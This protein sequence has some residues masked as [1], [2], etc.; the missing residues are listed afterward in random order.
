MRVSIAQIMDIRQ[1][2]TGNPLPY[3]RHAKYRNLQ[4]N[5]EISK[6]SI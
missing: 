6:F 3:A 2:F 4:W 1:V 5:V